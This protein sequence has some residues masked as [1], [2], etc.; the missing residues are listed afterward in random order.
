MKNN[1][2]SDKF[3]IRIILKALVLLLIFNYAFIT[4]SKLPFGRL[5][6]YNYL[7]TGRERLPFG[8]NPGQSYNLTMYDLEAMVAS[9]KISAPK[10]ENS[11]FRVVLL[12]DSSIWGFLQE[13]DDTLAGILN[14]K[15]DFTCRNRNLEIY[16]LGYPSL[17]VVKDLL[18]LDRIE[19]YNPDLVVWFI[20]L[21]SL[22]RKEQ[23][24]TPLMENN[25]ILRN[26]LVENYGVFFNKVEIEPLNYTF[27][28]QRRRIADWIRL[29]LYGIMWS[30]TEI[31]H[32]ISGE[33][34]PAQRDFEPDD[35]YK[36]FRRYQ[37]ESQDLAFDVLFNPSNVVTNVEFIYIN[38]PILISSGENNDIRYNFYYPRWA[39]DFYRE[40]I[41]QKAEE[42]GIEYYD[43]WNI[44][45]ESE[46]TNSAIHLTKN[47]EQ[48]LATRV[49][50]ILENYCSPHH[51]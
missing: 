22:L 5:S 26:K 25:H 42:M 28:E 31:D 24:E 19:R 39:Y 23:L 6:L 49:Y 2:P 37:I 27:F 36:D 30:A 1:S 18:I 48:I 17:S 40:A 8:E 7:I 34:T 11:E 43:L 9:H 35:S 4:I 46:F 29:Q 38:E 15:V 33:F 47:G 16:N 21:E 13:N 3:F 45:P 14:K 12:G 41:Q 50:E 10:P 44:V 32:E 20:T 51:D